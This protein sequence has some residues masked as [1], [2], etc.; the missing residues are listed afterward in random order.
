MNKLWILVIALFT[1]ACVGTPPVGYFTPA[2]T[3]SIAEAQ[4]ALEAAEADLSYAEAQA[5][6]STASARATHEAATQ[7]AAATSTAI[8]YQL[9]SETQAAALIINATGTAQANV[10]ATATQAALAT[11][12]AIAEVQ[13]TGTA[14]VVETRTAIQLREEESAAN[15]RMLVN[16][17][18]Q[19]GWGVGLVFLGVVLIALAAKLGSKIGTAFAL[20][21]MVIETRSGTAFLG[22]I[23]SPTKSLTQ[24]DPFKALLGTV[25]GVG[26]PLAINEPDNLSQAPSAGKA[27]SIV[28]NGL[29]GTHLLEREEPPEVFQKRRLALRLLRAAMLAE[30]ANSTRIPRWTDLPG[31]TS[32][33]SWMRATQALNGALDKSKKG[34][35]VKPEYG[36]LI[37]LYESVGQRKV[38]IN[39]N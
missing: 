2:P 12:T 37:E 24:P 32:G 27:D 29:G 4:A 14:Q 19:I 28:V 22:Y 23:T 33:D 15:N 1:S 10:Q 9:A 20:R 17:I 6:A 18:L 5:A 21:M 34:T 38:K 13:A 39:A 8:A 7:I 3:L 26:R 11:G 16:T 36:T 31:F 35:F 30:G 25:M